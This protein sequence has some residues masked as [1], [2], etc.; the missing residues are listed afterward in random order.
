MGASDDVMTDACEYLAVKEVGRAPRLERP[1]FEAGTR[2][3]RLFQP[4]AA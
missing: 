2:R 4:A 3:M 1:S